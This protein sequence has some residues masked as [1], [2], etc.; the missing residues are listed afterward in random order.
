VDIAQRTVT[1]PAGYRVPVSF[2][3]MD[4]YDEEGIIILTN[5]EKIVEVPVILVSP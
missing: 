3:M 4:D 1:I 5:G 2:Q